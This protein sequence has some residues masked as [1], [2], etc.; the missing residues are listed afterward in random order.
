MIDGYIKEDEK[1]DG[2]DGFHSGKWWRGHWEKTGLVE[3]TAC[4]DFDDPK[5]ADEGLYVTEGFDT[6]NFALIVMEAVKK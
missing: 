3:N 2:A 1:C 4:Y 6:S 5:S